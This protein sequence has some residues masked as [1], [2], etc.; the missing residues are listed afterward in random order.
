MCTWLVAPTAIYL[1]PQH[2]GLLWC[3]SGLSRQFD[4]SPSVRIGSKNSQFELLRRFLWQFLA[5][6]QSTLHST[7]VQCGSIGLHHGYCREVNLVC[8][9][10]C[11][12][13]H[14]Q[15]TGEGGTDMDG[16]ERGIWLEKQEECSSDSDTHC[17]HPGGTDPAELILHWGEHTH[18]HA[19]MHELS[20][21]LTSF[22]CA[23]RFCLF[24]TLCL[25]PSLSLCLSHTQTH[26]T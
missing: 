21:K 20:H 18:K 6:S 23:L 8:W 25:S 10:S 26:S 3:T 14:M 1:F 11:F 12:P 16:E 22:F 9:C 17:Y 13:T 2:H 15:R 19:R 7:T 4:I 24:S 5:V